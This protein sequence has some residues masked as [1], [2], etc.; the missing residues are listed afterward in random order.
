M[1][2]KGKGMTLRLARRIRGNYEIT[3]RTAYGVLVV[4]S[5]SH[6]L[7]DMLQ[8]VVPAVY[9]IL[10]DSYSLSFVQ[11]GIITFLLQLTSSVIQPFVGLYADRRPRP[12]S[13]AWGMCFT[14]AGL[15]LLAWAGSFATILLAVCCIGIGSAVFHPEA[16]R[17]AQMASGGKKGLAQSIFQVGGNGG[18]ALG[19]LLAALVVLPYGQHTISAFAL[20]AVVACLLLVRIGGWYSARLAYSTAHHTPHPQATHG[21]SPRMVRLCMAMLVVLIFSKYFYTACITNYFTF[22]LI[23]KFHVSVQTSQLCLFAYLAAFAAGTL[24]GGML[25]DRYGRKYV[26]LGSIFGSAPFALLLPYADLLWTVVLV[27]VVG[28][29]ISSAFSAILVY[30]TDLMP[31]K[32]G[33]IAGVFFGLM[34]G[35]GGIASALFGWMADCTG[36]QHVFHLSC[37]LPLLGVVAV[38]LPNIKS[39]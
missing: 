28:L 14:L 24:L 37:Y 34:F 23:E 6:L 29:V 16:S 7:N 10:K 8:S 17:V 31:D 25:G 32:V 22:Y 11:I 2:W 39:H 12:Y 38:F 20:L 21:L 33:V 13:L 35:L 4:I 27:V 1:E 36:I 18:S 30:A 19:P 15:L 5:L 26:I 3:E 9:P